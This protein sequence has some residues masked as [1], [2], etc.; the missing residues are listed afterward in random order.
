MTVQ[1]HD[2]VQVR[3]LLAALDPGPVESPTAH[4]LIARGHRLAR[5]RALARVLT[6]TGVGVLLVATLLFWHASIA[7]P[8]AASGVPSPTP[9]ASRVVSGSPSPAPTSSGLGSWRLTRTYLSNTYDPAGG[10]R[11]DPAPASLIPHRTPEQV[12]QLFRSGLGGSA[13]QE[14]GTQ[15]TVRFG[16]VTGQAEGTGTGGQLTS[17]PVSNKPAWIVVV[18]G[19]QQVS[20]GPGPQPSLGKG[21]LS[22]VIDDQTGQEIF[23]TYINGTDPNIK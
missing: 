12:L 4:Q 15:V 16:L 10:Y 13:L 2:E 19:V 21:F 3:A 9:T 1:D 18:S 7:G 6:G 22:E 23:G 11:M 17:Y 14:P 5:R 8:T 20:Y